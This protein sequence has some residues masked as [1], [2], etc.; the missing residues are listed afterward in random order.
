MGRERGAGRKVEGQSG[1]DPHWSA[2]AEMW[3]PSRVLGRE[4]LG[5]SLAIRYSRLQSFG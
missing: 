3:P 4:A 2:C 5:P 1:V